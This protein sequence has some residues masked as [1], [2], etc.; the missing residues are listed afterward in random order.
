M[1]SAA[2]ERARRRW[3]GEVERLGHEIS[4]FQAPEGVA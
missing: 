3:Q 2:D 4:R 1:M